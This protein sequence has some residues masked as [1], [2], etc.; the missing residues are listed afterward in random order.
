MLAPVQQFKTMEVGDKIVKLELLD[1]QGM[2][3]FHNSVP[4]QIYNNAEGAV[5][6]FDCTSRETF[7]NVDSWLQLI[8]T[9]GN[10]GI[11]KILVANK[12]DLTRSISTNEGDIFAGERAM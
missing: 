2:E 9:N 5:V 12:I 7:K 1:T 4:R 8:E 10:E 11:E 3:R 6:V